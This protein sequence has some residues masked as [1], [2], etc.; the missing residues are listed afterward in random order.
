MW[1]IFLESSPRI[2]GR[3]EHVGVVPRMGVGRHMPSTDHDPQ[4]TILEPNRRRRPTGARRVTLA[5]VAL[6]LG[7]GGLVAANVYA[8]ASEGGWGKEGS[9][10]AAD[11][12]LRSAGM[13][14]VDCPDVGARLT[15]VPEAA[16]GDVDRELAQLDQQIA[17]AYQ[18]LQQSADAL[19]QDPGAADNSVMNPLKDKRTATLGR[20]ADA[21]GRAG[22]RPDK[23]DAL[24]PC[25]LRP[26][27]AAPGAK[28]RNPPPPPRVRAR[29]RTAAPGRA[30]TDPSPPTTLTSTPYSP[31]PPR[32]P[33]AAPS[34]PSA[35]ST[36][37][38]CSTRTT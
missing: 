35:G 29:A 21:I 18:R 34:A 30:A 4:G 26:A 12:Q 28:A 31:T 5:A 19:R 6:M 22:N 23:L 38:A 33:P 11:A 9:G 27:E 2:P 1:P 36:R 10:D 15:D 20:I 3:G 16:R 14:T 13:A 24:A 37:T 32:R 17:E 7:G 8:S 25:T